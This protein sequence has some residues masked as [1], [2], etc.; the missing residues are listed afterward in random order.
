MMKEDSSLQKKPKR[1]EMSDEERVRDFQRKLYQKA[2]QEKEYRF[3]VL[4]DKVSLKHFLREAYKRVKANRGAS[5]VDGITFEEIEEAGLEKFIE[6][7][8]IE[9]KTES[10]RPQPVRRVM[11]PKANGKMR[12][13]GI[14]TIKDRVVQM[15]CKI[16]IEPIYE[17]DFEDCSYG[18]RPKR[19]ASDAM[20]AVKSNLIEDRTEVYDADLSNY[21]DTI[22]HD[23]LLKTISVRI[24]DSKVIHL[25]KM[26]LKTPIEE[27]GKLKGGK[28]NKIGTPQGGVISPL[29][30]NIYLHLLDK[31]VNRADGIFKKCG[32]KIVRYA[33]DFVLMG[34]KIP[35]AALDK[36]NELIT[37][38][39][40]TINE[41]KSRIVD[42]RSR[43][44]EYLGFEIRY[45]K[46][47][48]G[49]GKRYWN[50]IP[51]GKSSKRIRKAMKEYLQTRG[52]LPAEMIVK[53]L[54]AKIR[55]WLNYF[56]VKGVSYPAMSRRKLRWY[57]YERLNRY[58][59]KKSQRKSKLYGCRAFEK[60]VNLYGLI[61]PTKYTPLALAKA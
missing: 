27:E 24:S 18:F 22:P 10:Y 12:P 31:V 44:F 59:R 54:N 50:I 45:D 28:K 40:L 5:G 46:D 38:M 13:L 1:S 9:I 60:L 4:Y 2:K 34:K 15:S 33:D 25:I 21:F 37:R 42:A 49:R 19:S 36:L 35:P 53:G 23:K 7:L 51:S 14:P 29:L 6:E 32:I 57:L 41:D 56:T 39:G 55:G 16:V 30:A 8:S 61:D 52:H 26:W 11:I 17:A 48:R 43:S 20:S 58:Y 3:Y 47:L